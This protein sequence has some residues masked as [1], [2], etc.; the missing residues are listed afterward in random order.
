MKV[1]DLVK[2]TAEFKSDYAYKFNQGY[3][4]DYGIVIMLWGREENP[5]ILWNNGE[6]WGTDKSH[7]EVVS[8]ER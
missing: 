5:R 2:W 3:G 4:A 6:I 8:D 7:V 1:G